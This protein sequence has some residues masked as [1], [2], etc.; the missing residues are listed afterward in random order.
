MFEY[1]Y[2]RWFG[3]EKGSPSFELRTRYPHAS[4]NVFVVDVLEC[5]TVALDAALLFDC[6]R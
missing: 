3:S 1:N 4:Q 6:C 5:R 2:D